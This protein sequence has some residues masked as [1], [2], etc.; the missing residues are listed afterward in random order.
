MLQQALFGSLREP[1]HGDHSI[2]DINAREICAVAPICAL[3]LWIG[4]MPQPLL[5]TIRPDVDAVVAAYSPKLNDED[6]V[7][8][9][10][11]RTQASSNLQTSLERISE[12]RGDAVNPRLPPGA[13]STSLRTLL[14][15][16]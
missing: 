7:A 3:C 8:A 2:F 9:L 12:Y 6:R 10:V 15:H 13:A 4:V 14:Q 1:A 16:R 5:D 11:D